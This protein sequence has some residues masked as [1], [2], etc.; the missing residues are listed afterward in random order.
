MTDVQTKREGEHGCQFAA[1]TEIKC[2]S[3]VLHSFFFF[4]VKFLPLSCSSLTPLPSLSFSPLVLSPLSLPS[5][6]L[7]DL[8]WRL[9]KD[10]CV[11]VAAVVVHTS[12]LL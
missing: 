10:G 7:S 12:V 8:I 11:S 4:L 6:S 5:F 1:S 3:A 2:L 9:I